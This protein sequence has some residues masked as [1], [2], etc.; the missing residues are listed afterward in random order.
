MKQKTALVARVLLG[1]IYFIFGLNFFLHFIPVPPPP[2][3]GAKFLGALFETGYI[4]PTIKVLEVV[5]GAFLLGGYFV[6]LALVVLAPITVNIVLYHTLLAPE[7][8]AMA[9]LM[10][11][12]HLFLAWTNRS[13]YSAVLSAK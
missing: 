10:L 6:P 12:L 9:I 4:F 3:A 7:G 11:A 8:A 5:F 1:A 13:K 2:E